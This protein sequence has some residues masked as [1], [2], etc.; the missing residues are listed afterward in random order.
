VAIP[1]TGLYVGVLTLFLLVL[2]NEVVFLRRSRKISLGFGGDKDLGRAIRV[3]GN[4]AENV[5]FALLVLGALE[6]SGAPV[7]ELHAFGGTVIASR[8]LHRLGLRG[9]GGLSVGRFWGMTALW[10]A[11]GVG[12]IDLIRRS[13]FP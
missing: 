7:W 9:R 8:V 12:A 13:V 2:G 6:L 4:F 1:I 5:P 10:V 11:M 3:H